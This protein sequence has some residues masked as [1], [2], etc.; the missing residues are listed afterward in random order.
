MRFGSPDDLNRFITVV[1][2]E[3]EAAGFHEDERR[4]GGIQSA[5]FTTGSEWLGELGLAVKEIHCR[6]K[7]P[8]HLEAKLDSIMEAVRIGWPTM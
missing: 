1:R 8:A 5:C 7:L 6:T 3:L 4:L 2:A